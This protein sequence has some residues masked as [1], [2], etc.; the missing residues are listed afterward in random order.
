MHSPEH[1]LS[2]CHNILSTSHYLTKEYRAKDIKPN[3]SRSSPIYA[4]KCK[5][6]LEKQDHSARMITS[7]KPLLFFLWGLYHLY[8]PQTLQQSLAAQLMQPT[9]WRELHRTLGV[10]LTGITTPGRNNL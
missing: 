10:R 6:L 3:S 2:F 9:I 4:F 7:N 5:R 8:T 1:Y